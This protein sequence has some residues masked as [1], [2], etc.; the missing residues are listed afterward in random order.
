MEGFKEKML[1]RWAAWSVTQYKKALLIILLIT[2]TA[3]IGTS[4][5][6]MEMTFFSILPR[7]SA[8]VRDLEK[9]TRE[10]A[11]SSQIILV[12]DARSIE[13]PDE[14]EIAVKKTLDA[15]TKEF[16]KPKWSGTLDGVTSGIDLDFIRNHAMMLTKPEDQKRL[17]NIYRNPDLLPFL[18]HLN[19]DFEKEYSGNDKNLEDDEM[20]ATAQIRGLGQILGLLENQ[21]SGKTAEDKTMEEALDQ[22]LF[23]DPVILS[24]DNKM[25][26]IM[27][28]PNFTIDDFLRFTEI[29]DLEKKA[30]EIAHN[31]DVKAGFTGFL[32]V[33]KDE[34]VTSEQGLGISMIA[35][36]ILVI[37]LMVLVFRMKSVPLIAGLPLFLGI[38]WT[39][40]VTG[41]VVHR[42]N[43]MTAMYMVALIGLGIDYA[44]HI[45]SSYI[46]FRDQGLD[47]KPAMVKAYSTS[48]PGIITGGLTTAAAFLALMFAKTSMVSELGLVAGLG[49][50]CE[51]AAM[52]IIIPPLLALRHQRLI[53][54]G[55]ADTV[56]SGKVKIR[57][58]LA[59]G[60]GKMVVRRPGLYVIL[61]FIAGI[62]LATQ[63]GK[64]R[65]EDNMMN[66]EAKGLKSIELQGT[67]VDEFDMAVD[68]LQI[69]STNLDEISPLVD[70]LKSLDSVKTA[71]AVSLFLPSESE[72]SERLPLTDELK[73]ILSSVEEPQNV[74][75]DI[76]KDELYRLEMNLVEMGDMAYLGQMSRLGNELNRLTSLDEN[77]VKTGESVFDRITDTLED[78]SEG[79]QVALGKFQKI[80]RPHLL[81]RLNDMANTEKITQGALSDTIK[82]TFISRDGKSYLISISP[83]QNPW[84]GDFREIL[85]TQVSSVT[86]R[87]TGMILAANQMNDAARIDGLFA[88]R[89]AVIVVF[90]L[91]LLDFRNL[92]LAAITFI[93]LVMSFAGLFGIM[94]LTGIKFDFL[95]IISIP[96][97]IGI[98]VD[99]AVH[100]NH[101]YLIEGKGNMAKVIGAT[102]TAVFLATL[103][104]IIGFGSFIPSIMRAM[105]GTGIVL[106]IAM[107]LAFINSVLLHPAILIFVREKAHW[108]IKPW[109][110]E[111]K[112]QINE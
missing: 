44:I 101:R 67:L 15:M 1:G 36:F 17:I 25:G 87:A 58:N 28:R 86:N 63:A 70:K 95:N 30:D 5:L 56:H 57:S 73:K 26:I 105:R 27:L 45:L 66:M 82:D 37:T 21:L 52:L 92:K 7:E 47:F 9:I 110:S 42:L 53:K 13:D 62:S 10:F 91:L 85:T 51:M 43:I 111:E 78:T 60:L 55:K 80:M 46:Q 32:V 6:K 68:G 99:N 22:F 48:G 11:S 79:N 108:S 8:Q 71:E 16:S 94:A 100:I 59:S 35:A 90:L 84:E 72:Y 65:I 14:A 34:M 2:V 54:K 29:E 93:P 98:G 12:V 112:E 75:A 40:G 97:L 61:L 88:T 109:G 89:I 49:I 24:R 20:Q 96:L 41:F 18:T 19:D 31:M 76:L 102:G 103:T 104:T 4:F 83:R 33:G 74:D 50:L 23:G 38:F 69:L 107:T 3:G 106:V 39:A 64:V 81:E 77:G